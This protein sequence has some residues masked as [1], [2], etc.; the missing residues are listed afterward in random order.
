MKEKMGNSPPSIP[1][2]DYKYG[3]KVG[4]DGHSMVSLKTLFKK[5]NPIQDEHHLP[6]NYIGP[7]YY[8]VDDKTI[9]KRRGG[10]LP[11]AQD[12]S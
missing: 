8:D 1:S 7:G 11:Y 9:S 6:E 3:Y 2:G 10:A 5:T 12:S 4:L